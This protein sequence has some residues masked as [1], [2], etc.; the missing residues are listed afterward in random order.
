MPDVK[1][2]AYARLGIVNP[3]QTL[4]AGGERRV[5]CRAGVKWIRLFFV[6]K[7]CAQIE[8]CLGFG[9]RGTVIERGVVMGREG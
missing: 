3:P 2:P 6:K 4:H 5:I 1:P 8:L 9:E 7:C